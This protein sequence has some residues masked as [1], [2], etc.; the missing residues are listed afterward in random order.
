MRTVARLGQ[1]VQWPLVEEG[2]SPWLKALLT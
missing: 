2:D 1:G